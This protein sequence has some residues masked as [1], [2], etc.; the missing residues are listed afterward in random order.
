[1]RKRLY[2]VH[3]LLNNINMKSMIIRHVESIWKLSAVVVL[4]SFFSLLVFFQPYAFAETHEA[5]FRPWSGYWW[6]YTSGGLGTGLDY[7]GRPAPLEK[8]NLLTTGVTSGPALTEYLEVHYDPEAPYWYGL[9]LYWARAASYEHFY[10]LPSSE[11]NIVFRVGDKKGLLTLAH[12]YDIGESTQGSLPEEFHFWLLTYIK[13]QRKA[14]VA[15]LATGEEVWSYP[16]YKY[17]MTTSLSGNVE[18]VSVRIYAANDSVKP[19]YMGTAVYTDDYTYNLFL[20][21]SGAI[22]GGEWTGRSIANHPEILTYSINVSDT[23]PGLDYQEI[24]RLAGSRDDFLE[25]GSE[26]VEI[27]PGT[28]NLVLLDEDV[29]TIPS[30]PGDI[31]SVRIDKEPGSLQDI[32][33]VVTDGDGTEVQR[34]I[35]SDGSPLN[36][37][38]TSSTPPYLIRLTQGDYADPNIYV[39]KA[40]VKR[41]YNQEVPY[42]PKAS[43]WSGFA[44]TNP[45]STGIERVTL[46]TQDAD[47]APIQTV[48]GPLRLEPGEKRIFLFDDLPVRLHELSE[49]TRLTLTA[50]GPVDLLNLIG[51]GDRFLATFVQGNARGSRLVIPDTAPSSLTTGVMMFGGVRNESFEETS[52]TIRVYSAEGVLQKEVAEPIAARGWFSITPGSYPFYTMPK[53]GWIEIIGNGVQPLSGF[54]YTSASSGVETLFALPVSSSR[55]IVPHVPEPGYWSTQVT[56]INPNDQENHVRLHLALAGADMEGDFN[57]VLAPREKKVLEIQDQFGK[58]AGEPL[59]HSILEITGLYPLVGYVTYSA[60]NGN[61][62]ASYPLLEDTNLKST[63]SLPHYPGNDGNW[64]TGVVVCNP[65]SFAV[66]VRMEPFDRDGNLME[67]HEISVKLDAGAYDVFEVASRF[68]ESA[69]GISFI[70]FRME[71]DSGAIG[72]FYLYGDSGS[73]IFSGANM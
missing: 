26:T 53:S 29:Y 50:D 66:T 61:D 36:I 51:K 63:L 2:G 54:Q 57:I 60:P 40:D 15:D 64:W 18:S 19:D 44:L 10:I 59:Y 72:G 62:N 48:L 37:M 43:E 32:D 71:E 8:Y 24:V 22:T 42:I 27:S 28:Y 31:L 23:F 5:F 20:D 70:K 30:V 49:T 73:R 41:S 47:G 14:F 58:S 34:A 12:K 16:I 4:F 35:V 6:P 55:K 17:E 45:G 3:G 25:K 38:I 7:R 68:G 56:L 52:V 11:N 69:P 39:L 46:T 1:M 67:G 65:S 21:G 13:D 9:C 33:V